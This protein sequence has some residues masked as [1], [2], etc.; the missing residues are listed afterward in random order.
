MSGV[1]TGGC[2]CGA[3][4]FRVEGR[5]REVSICHCRMCQKATGGLFGPFAS[6]RTA[7]LAWTRGERKLFRSSQFIARGFCGDCGTPLT[8]EAASGVGASIGLTVGAFDN[9]SALKPQR[10][11]MVADRI[12]WFVEL[13]GVPERSAAEDAARAAGYPAVISRQHPDH[14]TN[15]WPPDQ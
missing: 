11:I 9:P 6:V 12:P 10:Q 1:L 5:P 3:V 14:D 2:Q 13:A 15:V 7:D 4:R 8:F